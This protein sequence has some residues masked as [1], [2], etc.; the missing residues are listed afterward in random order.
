MPKPNLNQIIDS[1][2]TDC[3]GKEVVAK[4]TETIVCGN[5]LTDTTVDW[6][7]YININT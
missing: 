3:C 4:N 1:F 2:R 5:C 6:F 7:N